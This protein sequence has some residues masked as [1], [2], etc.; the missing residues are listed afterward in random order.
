VDRVAACD[1]S[2]DG[3]CNFGDLTPFVNLLTG[4]P[5]AAASVPEP[6]TL[7][8]FALAGLVLAWRRRRC[9]G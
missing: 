7:T 5:G 6:C 3:L 8:L 9:G 4:G 2:G 1:A